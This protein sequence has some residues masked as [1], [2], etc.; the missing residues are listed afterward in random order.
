MNGE[1][2]FVDTNA[3]IKFLEGRN[4]IVNLLD[5]KILCMSVI[6]E[7]ELL[8][9]QHITS[10]ERLLIRSFIADCFVIGLDNTVK[11][12]AI[13]IRLSNNL[14]LPDAIVAASAIVMA[15]P[16]V[17]SDNQFKTIERLNILLFN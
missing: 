10:Q 11:E 3:I 16:I 5:G 2:I 17:T 12:K 1:F 14:K 15:L 6:T 7:M 4:D 8:C 13:Q 9:K